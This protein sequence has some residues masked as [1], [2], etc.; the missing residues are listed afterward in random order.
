MKLAGTTRDAVATREESPTRAP[1]I[2]LDLG[3]E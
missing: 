2:D 3:L 1:Q